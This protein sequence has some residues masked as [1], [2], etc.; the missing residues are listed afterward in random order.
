MLEVGQKEINAIAEVLRSGQMF[1]YHA[2]GQCE[3]FEQRYAEMLGVKH[4]C[5]TSSGTTALTAAMVGLEIGPG[6][7]VVVPAHTYM[8]TA[9]AVLAAGAIPVL[10]D[11]DESITLDPVALETVIGPRTRAVVPVHM[12]GVACDMRAIRRVA[13]K[14]D[15][16]IVE[17]ACQAV[18]GSYRGKPL[19]TLGDAAGFSFNYF[20]NMTCG[21][22]GAVATNRKAVA[23][24]V[25]TM[26]DC[27]NAYWTG[28]K[29]DVRPF[30]SNGSRASE[31]EGAL[32]NVQ[33]DRIGTLVSR[34]REQKQRIAAETADAGLTPAP[35]HNPDGECATQISYLF[36]TP[37]RAD[38]FAERVGG[39]VT[40]KTG[41]HTY[42]EW[43]P[44]LAKRGSHHPAL[45]PFRLPANRGCRKQYG[46]TVCKA[47]LGLLART[48]MVNLNPR[49]TKTDVKQK[50]RAINEAAEAVLD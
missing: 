44:I 5:L 46:K 20:K 47:S 9:V 33:L 36:D 22:G 21:E 25:R 12:W 10:C 45:D 30:V 16:L 37:A 43:D 48:V 27:C 24:R 15:L 13:K 17:D 50:I 31:I 18:G 7:E 41:R 1:R 29:A 11:I 35:V 14:H 42:T 40:G 38:R 23:N 32:L 2:G 4:V 19:G 3:R 49:A 26:I 39:T 6:D 34:L 8:A 28:R